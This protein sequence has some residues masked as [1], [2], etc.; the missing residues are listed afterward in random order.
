MSLFYIN[1]KAL[2]TK[3]GMHSAFEATSVASM[4]LMLLAIGIDGFGFGF[5]GGFKKPMKSMI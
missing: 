1:Y 4:P 2:R 3:I 5:G